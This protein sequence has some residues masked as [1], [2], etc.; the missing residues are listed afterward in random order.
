M[1][2]KKK[3]ISKKELHLLLTCRVFIIFIISIEA[4][5][6]FPFSLSVIQKNEKP[7]SSVMKDLHFSQTLK[8]TQ[9]FI[10]TVF[11][12]LSKIWSVWSD[13]WSSFLPI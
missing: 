1:Q 6:K 2:E 7:E 3:W 10:T 4:H 13:S 9:N 5:G 8:H 12:L 11:P